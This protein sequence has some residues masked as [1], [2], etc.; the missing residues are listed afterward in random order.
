MH[1]PAGS[2]KYATFGGIVST[3]N[4][5]GFAGCRSLALSPALDLRAYTGIRLRVRGDATRRR[6]KAIVRDSYDWNGIA[7]SQSFDV[8]PA[9]DD[10]EVGR[11]GR[12][13][14]CRL[15]PLCRHSLRGACRARP[16]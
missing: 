14:R 15:T 3:D 11:R 10:G 8:L 5:G 9:A 16:R 1:S 4:N 2:S 13:S 7:W 6:Y 12:R